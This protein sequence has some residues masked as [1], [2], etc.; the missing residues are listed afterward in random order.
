MKLKFT[1]SFKI[2]SS[3][4]EFKI[5]MFPSWILFRSSSPRI[6]EFLSIK[7]SFPKSLSTRRLERVASVF[8][9]TGACSI[10]EKWHEHLICWNQMNKPYIYLSSF[11]EVKKPLQTFTYLLILFAGQKYS[12]SLTEGIFRQILRL[13]ELCQ[14]LKRLGKIHVQIL[15]KKIC[16]VIVIYHFWP[17]F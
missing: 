5:L 15:V 8:A 4:L 9:R 1:L 2:C 7:L 3:V 14:V 17:K 10:P 6:L 11:Y 16:K 12:F 13:R